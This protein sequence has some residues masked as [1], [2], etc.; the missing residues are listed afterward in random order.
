MCPMYEEC[1]KIRSI[2]GIRLE[3]KVKKNPVPFLCTLLNLCISYKHVDYG[4]PHLYCHNAD[5]VYVF[6][7]L[8]IYFCHFN[9]GFWLMQRV[10]LL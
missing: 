10:K 1:V 2:S 4:E 6:T 8:F 5:I 9:E 7:L 3:T